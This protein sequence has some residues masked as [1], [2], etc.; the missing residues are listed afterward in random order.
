MFVRLS[1][2]AMAAAACASA[3]GCDSLS[4]IKLEN[5]TITAAQVVAPGAFS[6]P[7]GRAGKGPNPYQSLP[8][9]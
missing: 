6:V 7:G 8:A 9:F 2:L 1:L 3:A 5:A 4:S